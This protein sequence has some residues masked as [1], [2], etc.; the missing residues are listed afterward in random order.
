MQQLNYLNLAIKYIELLK[1]VN[2]SIPE[3]LIKYCTHLP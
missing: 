1:L 2:N 3:K